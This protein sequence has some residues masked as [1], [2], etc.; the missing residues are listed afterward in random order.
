[1]EVA[2]ATQYMNYFEKLRQCCG[3]QMSVYN[4]LRL[5]G[6]NI[7]KYKSLSLYPNCEAIK[8]ITAI[9]RVFY[10][11]ELRKYSRSKDNDVNWSEIGDCAR[12][13]VM[14]R[15][16][17]DFNGSPFTGCNSTMDRVDRKQKKRKSFDVT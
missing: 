16:G 1:M 12:Y 7:T 17:K 3:F 9:E 11:H 6:C 10:S 5:H 8:N 13:D 14:I 2:E 15:D 4:R